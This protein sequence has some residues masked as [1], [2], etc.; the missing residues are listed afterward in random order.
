MKIALTDGTELFPI[1][2][3]G[4]RKRAYGVVRDALTFVFPVETDLN[5][6]DAI[7]TAENCGKITITD[8]E[9]NSYIHEGYTVR[10]ELSRKPVVVTQ[11]TD[12]TDAV[13]EQRVF[14]SMAQRTPAENQLKETQAVMDALLGV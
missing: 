8:D 4:G 6:M 12:T 11:A 5:E 14:V 13:V 1:I 2:A 10:A 7:F 9:E 3:T